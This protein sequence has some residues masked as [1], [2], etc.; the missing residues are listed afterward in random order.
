MVDPGLARAYLLAPISKFSPWR[1][2]DGRSPQMDFLQAAATHRIRVYRAGNRCGKTTVG[3]VDAVLRCLG[4]HPWA[5]QH[6]P[7]VI[8]WMVTLDWDN[9]GRVLWPALKPWLPM[10]Q[11]R[12][13]SWL[14]RSE[15]AIPQA[16]VFKNGSELHFRSADAKRERHQ[17]VKLT[18]AGLDEELD[19]EI[20]EE[21]EA[22]LLDVGG[23]LWCTLTPLARKGW[24]RDLERRP[25]CIT[26]RASMRDAAEAGLLDKGSVKS[27]RS[28]ER[29]VGKECRL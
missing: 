28:E 7:P 14:R 8:G 29:R 11:V 17:G 3:V 15:P 16:V 24:V 6:R 1:T 18:F 27:F 22:R 21:T 19:Q 12:S 10:D 4:W 9:V 25:D 2:A 20:V 26:V 23:H 13:I 5:T